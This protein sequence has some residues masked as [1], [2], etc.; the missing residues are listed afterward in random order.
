MTYQSGW[1][2]RPGPQLRLA[3]YQRPKFES[4]LFHVLIEFLDSVQQRTSPYHPSA[5]GQ[6]ERFRRQLKRA[7]MAH[8]NFQWFSVL[9]TILLGFRAIWKE[10]LEAKTTEIVYAVPNR[11]P[12]E[13]LIPTIGS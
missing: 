1:I 8:G 6:I 11:Q 4:S 3:M 7:I 5:N 2:S 10:D 12:G 13:F 9:R